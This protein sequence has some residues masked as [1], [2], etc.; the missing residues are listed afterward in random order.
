MLF[1]RL[2]N[3]FVSSPQPGY[4]PAVMAGVRRSPLFFIILAIYWLAGGLY[5]F[6]TPAW[7]APDEPAHYNYV[8][9]VTT[10][11]GFPELT[12]N[13]YNQAYL[14]ELTSRRFP[15][16]MSIVPICYEFHQPPFYY[17]LG[18]P[19]FVLSGGSLPILRF[20]SMAVLGGAV[21][22]LAFFIGRTIFPNRPAIA[23]GAMALVAFTPMH[24]AILSSINND[25]LAELILAAILYILVQRLMPSDQVAPSSY[26][27]NDWLLGLLLGLGLGAKTTVYIALPLVAVAL[28]W[29]STP[30]T[31]QGAGR[32][33]RKLA[34]QAAVVFGLAFLIIL[35][36]FGRNA[37]IY[38]NFDILGLKQHEAIVV[39]QLRT[40][41]YLAE[42]GWPVYLSDFATTTFHSFWGQ[43][44]WMAVPMDGRT[45]L[46]L[47]LLTLIAAG[48]LIGFAWRIRSP[49]RA[50][51]PE[52]NLSADQ[53]RALGLLGLATMLVG[54]AYVG[55]NLSFR[56]FQGRYLFP[57]LIPLAIFFAMGLREA[58]SPRWRWWLATGLATGWVWV[59]TTSLLKNEPDKWAILI[60]GLVFAAAAG[61]ALLAR[62]GFIPT[63]WVMMVCYGAL[64]FLALASPFWF[65]MPYLTP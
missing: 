56:Q 41:D 29:T 60:T 44:G 37:L 55:Y 33:W 49:R 65:I 1:R 54:L 18:M 21:V 43:F 24:L 10:Q 46:L 12:A 7:Q 2:L 30:K 8:R 61:R 38:G 20:L 62:Y 16:D 3:V 27:K 48:G 31:E 39:G 26:I 64:G 45:Y 19:V 9:A 5:A 51:G 23:Y 22:A 35:P 36:W 32:D 58:F 15:P 13:C 53:W 59:I 25:T 34:R 6:L 50:T 42:V 11:T 28:W 14:D 57:A 52:Y 47:T 17:L 4:N 40:T 63:S